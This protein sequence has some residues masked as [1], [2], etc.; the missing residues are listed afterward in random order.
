MKCMYCVWLVK[1]CVCFIRVCICLCSVVVLFLR[2]VESRV[3]VV[4]R[5][6]IMVGMGY[7][8]VVWDIWWVDYVEGFGVV[9][10]VD[11]VCGRM[12]EVDCVGYFNVNGW[13]CLCVGLVVGCVIL[14]F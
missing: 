8:V 6:F 7:Y 5:G 10:L 13:I 11:L 14:L 4:E 12:E 3:G 2:W 9:W 1:G